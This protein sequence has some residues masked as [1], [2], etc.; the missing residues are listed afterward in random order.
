MLERQARQGQGGGDTIVGGDT[1]NQQNGDSV[2]LSTQVDDTQNSADRMKRGSREA[3]GVDK[4]TPHF[5]GV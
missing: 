4:K 3:V 1:I 5:C 2:Q